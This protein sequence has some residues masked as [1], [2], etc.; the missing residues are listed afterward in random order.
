MAERL[1]VVR[2]LPWRR[3]RDPWAILVAEVMLQQTQVSRAQHAWS[4]LLA[5]LPNPAAAAAAGQADI[6]RR[7]EGLGYNR[8]AVGLY[9]AAVAMVEHHDGAVPASL[10]ELLALPGVG[11]YT[12]RAVLAFAF[13]QDVAVVDV[14]V[15]RV[16]SRAVAGRPLSTAILQRT[17]DGLVGEGD[18]WRHNQAL[19]DHG[20]LVCTARTPSCEG[21]TLRRSCAWRRGGSTAPDPAATTAG[22]SRP[23]S[24][25]EGS[26][27]QA[28]G[29]V[30]TLV[31]GGPADAAAIEALRRRHG[32]ARIDAAIDALGAEGIVGRLDGTVLLVDR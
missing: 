24:R 11:P 18:G 28:R 26:Q 27:R 6:V 19:L 17:A 13:E 14:N 12:A 23:Q 10:P 32:E 2:D 8:R 15:A 31:R 22:T 30:L 29:A 4:S 21:C 20:A 9:R 3:T 25:F 1:E 16:I 7:W 5:D